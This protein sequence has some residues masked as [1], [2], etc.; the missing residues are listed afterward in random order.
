MI[1]PSCSSKTPH[2]KTGSPPCLTIEM[3]FFCSLALLFCLDQTFCWFMGPESSGLVTSLHKTFFQS[4]WIHPTRRPYLLVYFL[5]SALKCF[6]PFIGSP[7]KSLAG[8]YSVAVIKHIVVFLQHPQRFSGTTH[9]KL[10]NNATSCVS[11]FLMTWKSSCSLRLSK[12][13]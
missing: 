4:I 5:Y 13:I 10:R 2:N 6:P 9:F 11:E 3:V 12:V 8:L 1:S 7:F